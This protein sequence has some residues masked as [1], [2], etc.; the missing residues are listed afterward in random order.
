VE[1]E[2][3]I[4]KMVKDV[5]DMAGYNVIRARSP[6]QAMEAIAQLK[7]PLSLVV[8]DV[9]LPEMSGPELVHKIR[10]IIPDVK[11]LLISGYGEWSVVHHQMVEPGTPFL[12]KPFSL[13]ALTQKVSSLI[14][15]Q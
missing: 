11:M 7:S 3:Q 15:V 1:D 6:S 12:Q 9:V 4:G 10:S 8:T 14:P 13:T 5:L 2:E